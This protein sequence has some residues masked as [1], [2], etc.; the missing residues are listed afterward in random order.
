ML[1]D[2]FKPFLHFVVENSTTAT[3]VVLALAT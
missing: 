1:G 2:F 3:G